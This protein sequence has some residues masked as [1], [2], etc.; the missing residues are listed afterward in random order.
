MANFC[1]TFK[2]SQLHYEFAVSLSVVYSPFQCSGG[3]DSCRCQCFCTELEA[4]EIV[5]PVCGCCGGQCSF[6]SVLVSPLQV[7]GLL[8]TSTAPLNAMRSS[9]PC[10]RLTERLATQCTLTTLCPFSG[11]MIFRLAVFYNLSNY[12]ER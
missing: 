1:L 11:F 2:H 9:F 7:V 4:H 5:L 12:P 3:D 6:S 10:L 8:S